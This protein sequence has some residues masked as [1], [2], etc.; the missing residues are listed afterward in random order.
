MPANFPANP[1]VGDR[2]TVGSTIREWNGVS[3]VSVGSQ[4]VIQSN[5]DGGSA[6]SVYMQNI[7]GGSASSVYTQNQIINGGTAGTF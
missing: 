1:R 7:Y 6:S 3:W 4:S 2:F 5:L